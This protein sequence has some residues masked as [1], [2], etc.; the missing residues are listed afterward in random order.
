MDA[1]RGRG[2]FVL[3]MTLVSIAVVAIVVGSLVGFVAQGSRFAR[4]YIARD[5]CRFA[6]QSA[7]E[8]AKAQIQARFKAY[9]GASGTTVKINPN[10]AKAYNWFDAVSDDRRTIG[11]A[12][13]FGRTSPLT[14]VDPPDGV[15]GCDVKVRIGRV[16]DHATD[17]AV[18]SVPVVAT[19]TYTYPD[20]L[21]VSAT[22]QESVRFATGQ[23]EV[24]DYAYFVNNY[25]WMSGSS[26]TINGDMRANGDVSLTGSTVNGFIYAAL[27]N[28]VGAA[29]N[30]T[31]AS[32]PSIKDIS[33]YRSAATTTSRA[34]PDIGDYNTPGAYDA[35]AA[36]GSITKALVGAV[37]GQAIVNEDSD[38]I[39]MPF[40]SDL[41]VYVEYAQENHG[42]LHCP[43]YSFVDSTGASRSVAAKDVNAHYSGTGPS[44][45]ASLADKGALVLVGTR[46]N[47][48]RVSGPVVVDSDVVITGYVT[49][50]GTIYSGRNVHIIGDIRY[51]NAPSWGHQDADDAATERANA[52]KDL[53]G[54]VAKGNIVVGDSSSSTWYRSV[55]SY[56][57][58]GSSSVVEQYQCDASD[59]AIGYPSR[60]GGSYTATERVTGLSDGMAQVAS[61]CGGWNRST[62]QFGKV[63]LL[64]TS[65]V[66]TE[67]YYD[68]YG[69]A[70][71]REK[72]VY[73]Y[74]LE[75]Q[76][77]RKFYETVCDDAVITGLKSS[78]IACIDAVLYNNHGIFGTP[79]A[80]GVSFNL[81][82][83]LVC[84]DEA[85]IFSGSGINFNWDMRLK[86]KRDN[87]V[88]DALGLPVGP[89][90]PF[91]VAWQEVPRSLNPAF[92]AEGGG[93]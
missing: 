11:V 36:G 43:G 64:T 57:N 16:V 26:I 70:R 32:S 52:S 14:L 51:V 93:Q 48:I 85:L 27:N 59:A 47:P 89:Q 67:T 5:R 88:T 63:R 87:A 21:E 29:G 65:H 38:P 25:G 6:A 17:S 92:D 79:G 24:F 13:R 73:D 46:Q 37:S 77:N 53:L 86:R 3:M 54:L 60:F 69:R 81:N 83:S 35:P 39:P 10:E 76:Y 40:V 22:I 50:Q 44:G 28:E 80:S 30:V 18:A 71:T 34:R 19:A 20:G 68:W 56:I 45:D 12:D 2:G 91:T 42:T 9:I 33:T 78:G 84:R 4:V 49:G 41:D 15:N 1:M 72:T 58:G 8:T 66:V 23:S 75:T 82:G 7:V 55:S 90:D 62:G 61:T 74:S 31:L